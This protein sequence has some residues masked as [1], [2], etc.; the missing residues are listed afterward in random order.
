MHLKNQTTP[1][2]CS[3]LKEECPSTYNKVDLY[4]GIGNLPDKCGKTLVK[5]RMPKNSRLEY[6]LITNDIFYQIFGIQIRSETVF[7]TGAREDALNHGKLHKIYPSDNFTVYW[8]DVIKDLYYL[9]MSKEL[10]NNTDLAPF[11]AINCLLAKQDS[12]SIESLEKVLEIWPLAK[13]FL[14]TYYPD[15]QNGYPDSAMKTACKIIKRYNDDICEV[16][17][18]IYKKGT[19]V[20]ALK[21]AAASQNEIMIHCK[22]Y[23]WEKCS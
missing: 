7:C 17:S 15:Y 1:I 2:N 14:T 23:C 16:F 12:L 22:F 10:I 9:E 3:K 21:E 11:V 5:R 4:R 18:K 20:E 19:T 6:H 8:S 13:E